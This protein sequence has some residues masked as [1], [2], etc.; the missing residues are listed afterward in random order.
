MLFVDALKN[1]PDFEKRVKNSIFQLLNKNRL[2]HFLRQP[3]SC[4]VL[5]L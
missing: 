3:V 2:P 5:Q 4:I 1:Y